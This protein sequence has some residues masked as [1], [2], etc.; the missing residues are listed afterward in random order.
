MRVSI[1][2]IVRDEPDLEDWIK[3][4]FMIGFDHIYLYDNCS[5]VP[6]KTRVKKYGNRVTVKLREG[7]NGQIASYMDCIESLKH[8]K[9]DEWV[10]FFDGDEYLNLKVHGNI[11]ELLLD[12]PNVDGL[13]FNW[14]LFGTNYQQNSNDKSVIERFTKSHRV[15]NRHYK[16]IVRVKH[17]LGCPVNA[18]YFNMVNPGRYQDLIGNVIS[19][20]YHDP[21]IGILIAE[22]NHY[23]CKTV[24]DF[25]RK[26]ER[27]IIENQKKHTSYHDC[28][29]HYWIA[30]WTDLDPNDPNAFAN[31]IDNFEMVERWGDKFNGK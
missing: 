19:S 17:V 18:H 30:E 16:S 23:F 25:S 21:N 29:K 26:I 24:E 13:V 1:C 6:V 28:V 10:A 7:V 15:S 4:N 27:G 22:L 12:Y 2:A 11:K 14:C 9:E 8:S 3:F 31:D 5:V 20:N